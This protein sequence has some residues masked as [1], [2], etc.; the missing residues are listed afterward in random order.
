MSIR[1]LRAEYNTDDGTSGGYP[2]AIDVLSNATFPRFSSKTA[3]DL[4]SKYRKI[5]IWGNVAAD[6]VQQSQYGLFDLPDIV[7]GN[8]IYNYIPAEG[9]GGLRA[10]WADIVPDLATLRRYGVGRLTA[11]ASVG[12]TVLTVDVRN[13]VLAAGAERIY[14]AD[15]AGIT[16]LLMIDKRSAPGTLD[17]TQQEE[18]VASNAV[19]VGSTV[20]LTLASPLTLSYPI[21][22]KVRSGPEK[23]DLEPSIDGLDL[24][25][26]GSTT[27][28]IGNVVLYAAS[29]WVDE[30][31]IELLASNGN[32]KITSARHGVAGGASP[33]TYNVATAA[34]PAWPAIG[35]VGPQF[36]IPAGTIAGTHAAGDKITFRTNASMR[37][38]F[39][40]L[41]HPANAALKS[42]TINMINLFEI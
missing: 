11:A 8:Q 13:A 30:I 19:A 10:T 12:D 36:T 9:P 35:V 20:T 22:A 14:R 23:I 7:L 26:A 42:H 34:A 24:T 5:V 41:Y 31:E 28:T 32:Y 38:Y 40:Q 3:E 15:G 33:I 39:I 6:P 37:S 17:W 25:A 4:F 1:F 21:G 16:D 27:I 2:L 29:T 18:I